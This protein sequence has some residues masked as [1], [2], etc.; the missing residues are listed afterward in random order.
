MFQ[1]KLPELQ[2]TKKNP[3]NNQ[4]QKDNNLPAAWKKLRDI[5]F[6]TLNLQKLK[7]QI[8][9]FPKNSYLFYVYL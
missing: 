5:Q 4:L 9:G 8:V 3:F 6:I 7:R 1:S 2:C